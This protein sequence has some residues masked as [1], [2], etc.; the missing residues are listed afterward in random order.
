M[1]V[2]LSNGK[3][4]GCDVIVSATGVTPNTSF[5]RDIPEVWYPSMY[6]IAAGVCS[7]CCYSL[8]LFIS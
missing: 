7:V 5:V 2:L 3:V 6:M 1:Y 4:Y 8:A